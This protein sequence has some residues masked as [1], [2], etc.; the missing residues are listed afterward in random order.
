MGR[1]AKNWTV[2]ESVTPY[3]Y[4]M[5]DGE[6]IEEKANL[7]MIIGMFAT[8]TVSLQKAADLAGRSVW[9]FAEI[10]KRYDIP[11][12]EYTQEDSR[13]DEVSLSK[14]A[15]GIYEEG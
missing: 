11:W 13:L 9:D 3:I 6:S 2:S 7:F 10:L 15:G 8:R 1:N 12:G 5:T 4:T 14:L